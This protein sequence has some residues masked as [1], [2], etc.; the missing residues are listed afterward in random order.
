MYA[1]LAESNKPEQECT[2]PSHNESSADDHCNSNLQ[3][4]NDNA[5]TDTDENKNMPA[6]GDIVL[7]DYQ[8]PCGHL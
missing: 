7:S 2:L 1:E 3:C 4:V 5:A 8:L 6:K